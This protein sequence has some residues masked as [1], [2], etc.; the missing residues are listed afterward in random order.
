[1]NNQ[2]HNPSILQRFY[3]RKSSFFAGIVAGAT[4]ISIFTGILIPQ[5]TLSTQLFS[6]KVHTTMLSQMADMPLTP[7]QL[8]TQATY[9][10]LPVGKVENYSVENAK[11]V[12]IYIPQIHQDPSS[13]QSDPTNNV[14]VTAQNQIYQIEKFL[15]KKSGSPLILT[16]GELY[17]QVPSSEIGFLSQRIYLRNALADKLQT[18]EKVLKTTSVD[19]AAER[20]LIATTQQAISS[21]DREVA[22]T[23]SAQELKANNNSVILYGVENQTT[24]DESKPLVRNY[25]YLQDRIAQLQT[26]TTQTASTG[27]VATQ[28]SAVIPA[29]VAQLMQLLQ[30]LGVG[31]TTTQNV[32]SYLTTKAQS[33]GKTNLADAVRSV[34]SAYNQLAQNAQVSQP[35]T[36]TMAASTTASSASPSR[37]DNPYAN[38]TNIQQLQNM[39]K[40]SETNLTKVVVDKRNSEI[41]ANSLKALQETRQHSLILQ[42]GAGHQDG[43]VKGLNAQGLSVIVVTPNQVLAHPSSN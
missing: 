31:N 2:L 12:V 42:L 23:G 10:N 38:F 22:L 18:L 19:P 24:L 41:A 13:P 28:T 36:Q 30:S 21:I 17:G 11:G 5:L 37:S 27:I 26:P 35:T 6:K 39:M 1:M 9:A 16:E 20:N 7:T 34:A 33:A 43:L 4:I 29:Q 40:T 32:F 14:A 3:N 8:G 15:V 25:V